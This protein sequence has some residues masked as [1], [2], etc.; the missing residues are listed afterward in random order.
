MLQRIEDVPAFRKHGQKVMLSCRSH[1]LPSLPSTP[2]P[3]ALAHIRHCEERSDEAIQ[4]SVHPAPGLLRF[5]RNDEAQAISFSRRAFCARALPSHC[6]KAPPNKKG[7]AERR[8]TRGRGPHR[9]FERARPITLP[10]RRAPRTVSRYREASAK[11]ARSP[12]GAPPRHSP[13]FQ[14]WLSFGLRFL[15]QRAD[16]S[17]LPCSELLAPR[18]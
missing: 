5:A 14:A 11:G 15:R 16:F 7:E 8:K 18:P 4:E 10:V 12:F 13:G 6:K 17:P 2:H 3:G 1:L 9:K